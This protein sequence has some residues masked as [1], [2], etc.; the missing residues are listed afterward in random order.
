MPRRALIVDDEPAVCGFIRGTLSATG[1]EVLPRTSGAEACQRT[2]KF[3]VVLFDL[4]MPTLDGAE[5]TR[6]TRDSGINQRTPIIMIRDDQSMPAVALPF[7][8]GASFFLYKPMDKAHLLKLIRALYL[9]R[10]M[11]RI[12]GS[13]FMMRRLNG[14]EV[15]I[16]LNQLT[17][18]ESG[19]L[20]DFPLPLIFRDDQQELSSKVPL[21]V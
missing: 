5:L 20:Q 1:V 2:E 6:Q 21:S 18:A 17:Q 16:Q 12:V 14:N 8:A 15:G 13:G 19:R 11:K 10:E 4:Q 7:A 3:T 9:S